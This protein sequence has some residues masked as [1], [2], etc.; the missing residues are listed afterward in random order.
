MKEND[1]WMNQLYFGDNLTILREL[2][3]DESVRL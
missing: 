3:R 2:V 1:H